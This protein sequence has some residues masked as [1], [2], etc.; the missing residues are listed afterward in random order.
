MDCDDVLTPEENASLAEDG[1]VEQD[2]P[3]PLDDV[4]ARML[5]EGALGCQWQG[6]G[7][8]IV[9]FA[10][11]QLDEAGWQERRAELVASGYTESN[12][13]FAGTLVAPSN[14]EE[15]YIPSVLYSG[16]MLYYVSYARF[17]TSVLAL[18]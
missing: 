16:G 12:D 13:P 10:Q 8:V 7:D 6:Q 2:P 3:L 9:W 5:D 18:P 4:M 15:N 1:L 14:A 11:Q 17:L